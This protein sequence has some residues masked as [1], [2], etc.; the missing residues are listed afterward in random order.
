MPEPNNTPMTRD[1][2]KGEV[3]RIMNDPSHAMHGAYAKGYPEAG[4]YI[5]ALYARIPGGSEKQTLDDSVISV[6]GADD[7]DP[8]AVQHD[9]SSQPNEDLEFQK[10]VDE[11]HKNRAVDMR[12]VSAEAQLVGD[13][14]LEY[15][16]SVTFMPTK[17]AEAQSHLLR[18]QYLVD[19]KALRS[20]PGVSQMSNKEV[21]ALA[22]AKLTEMYGPRYYDSI[23]GMLTML[24]GGE[25]GQ[26]VKE[27]FERRYLNQHQNRLTA[28]IRT[29]KYLMDLSRLY[30]YR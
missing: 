28:R 21:E 17:A 25:K 6:G 16:D 9:T 2:V 22:D 20:Q 10:T 15:L 27:K 29:G 13:D 7:G 5:D 8:T 18:S 4:K 24:F 12:S 1:E 30:Q 3:S 19:M 26:E 23:E 14:V 11:L